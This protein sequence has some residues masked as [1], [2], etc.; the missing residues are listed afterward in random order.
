MLDLPSY[1]L[2]TVTIEQMNAEEVSNTFYCRTEYAAFKEAYRMHRDT[3]TGWCRSNDV[4][5][6]NCDACQD[7]LV[8]G[9]ELMESPCCNEEDY[10]SAFDEP[11]QPELASSPHSIDDLEIVLH[12]EGGGSDQDD[13]D[14]QD[15][16]DS[17]GSQD[18][19]DE[20]PLSPVGA[21]FQEA[22]EKSGAVDDAAE[23][24]A[25][26]SRPQLFRARGSSWGT[27]GTPLAVKN[28]GGSYH[29]RGGSLDDWGGKASVQDAVRC[30][31]PEYAYR[32]LRLQG[33]SDLYIKTHFLPEGSPIGSSR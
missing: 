2:Q 30:H 31:G 23:E 4:L 21:M 15:S 28:A 22:D 5:P 9:V 12:I 29:R 33:F 13:Q 11:E 24:S 10:D 25:S 26:P 3:S 20:A 8:E 1:P 19:Q 7:D 32:T 14:N 6:C 18:S 27:G 16:Q 17:Q